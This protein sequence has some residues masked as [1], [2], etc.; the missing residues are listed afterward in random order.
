M[1]TENTISVEKLAR[2][3]GIS[4]MPL[5]PAVSAFYMDNALE[6]IRI[7]ESEVLPVAQVN[8]YSM[9][10]N[11]PYFQGSLCCD[12]KEGESWSDYTKRSY[13]ES[14]SFIMAMEG[15]GANHFGYVFTTFQP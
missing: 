1:E 5:S 7:L 14:I 9:N 8:A 13:K 11:G 4:G 2:V 10:S 6:V 15:A 3:N 12:Y